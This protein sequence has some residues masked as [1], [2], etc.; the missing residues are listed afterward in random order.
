MATRR[1]GEPEQGRAGQG[2]AG[3]GREGREGPSRAGQGRQ[4]ETPIMT[5]LPANASYLLSMFNLMQST[6]TD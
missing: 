5:N 2:R 6:D 4:A 1:Q 3:Q